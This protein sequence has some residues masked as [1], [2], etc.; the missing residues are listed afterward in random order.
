MASTLLNEMG[1]DSEV[2]E[3]QLAHTNKDRLRATYNKAQLM[4]TRTHMMQSWSNYLEG[5]MK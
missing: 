4:P 3:L 5:L 1:Y 2:I